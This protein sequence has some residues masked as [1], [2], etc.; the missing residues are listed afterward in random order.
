M[1]YDFSLGTRG[2]AALAAGVLAAGMLVFFAGLLT[3]VAAAGVSREP[4]LALADSLSAPVVAAEP[5]PP[6]APASA[7][8]AGA[9]AT[10][11]EGAA[12]TETAAGAGGGVPVALFRD[13]ERALA[14][15][16]R[17]GARGMDAV[18]EAEA[19]DAGVLF[20]VV[21]SGPRG[22]RP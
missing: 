13:E 16:D 21:A 7:P 14:L 1:R 6:A 3:G 8:A 19:D 17:M 22:G 20:R 12:D 2:A 15:R 9:D 4:V 10:P 5:C 18:I 11:A